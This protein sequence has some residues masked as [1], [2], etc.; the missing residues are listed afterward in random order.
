MYVHVQACVCTLR[1]F[2][3]HVSVWMYTYTTCT[4]LC[5]MY[6]C[7]CIHVLH[8][9]RCA[10]CVYVEVCIYTVCA[11]VYM[12]IHVCACVYMYIQN[13][14]DVMDMVGSKKETVMCLYTC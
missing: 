8:V 5:H 14:Y 10:I 1:K 13:M 12:Y 2:V 11:C 9:H 3:S 6:A 4:N 7:G